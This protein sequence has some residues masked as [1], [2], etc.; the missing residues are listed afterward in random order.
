MYD[1]IRVIA[2]LWEI[3]D[4]EANGRV[5]FLTRNFS[6]IVSPHGSLT[7]LLQHQ[8]LYNLYIIIGVKALR[9]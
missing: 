2:L 1:D 5:N 8:Q 9:D 4:T 7:I 3:E 6:T